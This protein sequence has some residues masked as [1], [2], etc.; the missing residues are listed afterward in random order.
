MS[1]ASIETVQRPDA[2]YEL[3]DEQAA[4]WHKVVGSM[5]A[6]WFPIET[7]GLLTQ[8]CKHVVAARRVAQLIDAQEKA[9]KLD[10]DAYDTLLKMQD[11]ESKVMGQLATRMRITQ[12]S[13]MRVE[14]L[15]KTKQVAKPWEQ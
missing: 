14:T 5:P 15:K 2:P 6:D 13:T 11:R 8:Y 4:E 12:Q 7:H 1:P 3:T 10:L 9:E